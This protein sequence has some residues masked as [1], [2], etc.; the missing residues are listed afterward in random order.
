LVAL[1]QLQFASFGMVSFQEDFHLQDDVHARRARKR[2]QRK[3]SAP[4]D[5]LCALRRYVTGF[6]ASESKK[7]GTEEILC[8][9]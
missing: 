3:S 5:F 8:A 4:S 6:A 9:L 7:K 1:S 2:A